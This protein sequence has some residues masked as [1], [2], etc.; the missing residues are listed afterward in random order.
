MQIKNVKPSE[1]LTTLDFPVHNEHILKIYFK[2]C[3]HDHMI[4]PPTPV[5]PFSIGLPLLKTKT[6]KAKK[7][8]KK[9][10]TFLND[11][12]KIKYL[13]VDGSHKTTALTLTHNHIR[14]AL[15]KKDAHVKEFKLLE[16]TGEIFSLSHSKY[17]I[18]SA[19]TDMAEHLQEGIFFETVEDKSQ[20]M[21]K[22]KVIPKYMIT[23]YK[24]KKK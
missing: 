7:Y 4:L 14:V 17:T 11:H 8:N 23:Y 1:I 10:K 20:R 16:E 12:P 19:L 6:E 24:K 18:E 9:I 13:M 22:E 15:L 5:I 2:I 21:V 3:Q